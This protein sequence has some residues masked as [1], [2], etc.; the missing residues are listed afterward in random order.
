MT[1]SISNFL[2]I[3]STCKGDQNYKE[4]DSHLFS[5]KSPK[6]NRYRFFN[7]YR[8]TGDDFAL[9]VNLRYHVLIL[10]RG[11]FFYKNNQNL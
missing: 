10:R 8:K 3:L 4:K 2:K 11:V 6:P 5:S 9:K 7:L 1:E